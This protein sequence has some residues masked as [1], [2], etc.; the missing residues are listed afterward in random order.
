VNRYTA[1]SYLRE[2]GRWNRNANHVDIGYPKRAAFITGA[3]VIRSTN[4]AEDVPD[5]VQFVDSVVVKLPQEVQKPIKAR[6]I[7]GLKDKDGC[8]ELR[9][10]RNAYRDA[11]ERG[12]WAVL[13]A[14]SNR[15]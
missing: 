5:D 4:P 1:I 10:S 13:G 9:L 3:G 8:K 11:V 6:F 14:L 7:V 12:I 15:L 2:W